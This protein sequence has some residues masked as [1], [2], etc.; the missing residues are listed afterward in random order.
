[1]I[2]RHLVVPAKLKIDCMARSHQIVGSCYTRQFWWRF[3]YLLLDW[4]LLLFEFRL[5]NY[6]LK[7]GSALFAIWRF[8]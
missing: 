2:D 4:E 1:L 7:H 5:M 8:R 6:N 3:W